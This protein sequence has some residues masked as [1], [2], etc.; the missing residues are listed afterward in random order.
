MKGQICLGHLRSGIAIVVMLLHCSLITFGQ[1]L[2][3]KAEKLLKE[4]KVLAAKGKFADANKSLQK[5]LNKNPKFAEGWARMGSNLFSMSSFDAAESAFRKSLDADSTF[6]SEVFF[7]LGMCQMKQD[8]YLDASESFY[9]Y[10][11]AQDAQ[12][13]KKE[14]AKRMAENLHFIHYAKGQPKP[15]HPISLG[16]GVN[17]QMHSEYSP[18]ISYDEKSIIFTRNTGQEDMY[19]AHQDSLG[20][21][22]EAVPMD[23][24]NTHQ[25][26]GA[27]A[28]SADGRFMVFTACDRKDSRGGC[29]LYY[30]EMQRNVWTKPKNFGPD[31]NSTSWDS[32]PTL[33]PD[34]HTLLFAST[35]PG[36]HGGSDIWMTTKM[37]NGAWKVPVNLG[38]AINTKYKDETPFLHADGQTL[39]FR[40]DGYPG[41]GDFDLYFS[42]YN[43]TA[44]TW[45]APT[46]LGYPINTFGDEGG[47]IVSLDGKSAYF[48]SDYDPVKQTNMGQLDIFT[49]ELY[50]EARPVPTTFVNGEV[51]DDKTNA[52]IDDAT[53][54]LRQ[55]DSNEEPI[56][57]LSD[58]NGA[59]L[60]S[61]TAGKRYLYHVLHKD[62]IFYSDFFDLSDLDTLYKPYNLKIRLH[63]LPSQQVSAD[64]I[65]NTP[66]VLK[67]IFFSSGSWALLKDSDHEIQQLYELLQQ[68]PQ[69]KIK[70]MGHTDNVG[71]DEDN[72]FLSQKRAEA[73]QEKLVGLGVNTSRITAIGYGESK[74]IDN[75]DTEFG[76]KNNRRTEFVLY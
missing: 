27:H 34:G 13:E 37:S 55:L 16:K 36:G 4:A 74:P 15:F 50:K 21:F 25:N 29:D 3:P 58:R 47:L 31:V 20:I 64:T 41:M 38:P 24:L 8:K 69:T 57:F 26:E 19:I 7:S 75:N 14:R 40:S 22:M 51:L 65:Q 53:I 66:I 18:S 76:R 6:S 32:Q 73:V 56:T 63:R 42:K 54:V 46:N 1:S 59:F 2:S 62:Y 23:A 43:D 52:I 49:F 33:S 39:Y 28:F 61:L 17:T 48:A 30:S 9:K 5:L 45:N 44:K 71:N 67:N 72:L 11:G 35:R 60:G 68:N 10:Y 12:A 70:I